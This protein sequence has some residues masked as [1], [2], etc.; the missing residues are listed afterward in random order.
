MKRRK[1]LLGLACLAAG[2]LVAIPGAR[3]AHAAA[4]ARIVSVG[5]SA[6]EIVY[7]LDAGGRLVAVD[8]TST[9]PAAANQL[10]RIGYMRAIS[11]EGVLSQRPDVVIATVDAGPA[12][13]LEQV[14]SAGVAVVRLSGEHTIESVL[15][16]VA[17]VGRAIG[18]E[19]RAAALGQEIRAQWQQ[20]LAD[21]A[22]LPSRPRV[23]FLLAH[24]GNV[25][26]V[27]GSGTAAAAMIAYARGVNAVEGT[28]GYKP[29]TSEGAV[30]AA[31]DVILVT[32]EGLEASGGVDKLLA[33]PGLATTPAGRHKRVVALDALPLLGF[34]PRTP[35]TVREL[36]AA[37]HR[38]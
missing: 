37:L 21:T 33:Q 32:R 14:R 18:A 4:P 3:V 30:A 15:A 2:P 38:A 13:A 10:P 17:T 20:T 6:T 16:N 9:F 23:L 1:A 22:K 27:S 34:G 26:M 24:T 25:P 8:S 11:A 36:A 31:P 35:A 5:G 19:E 7:A 28:R 29:L 12:I